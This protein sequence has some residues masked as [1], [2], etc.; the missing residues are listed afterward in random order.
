ME[1][2]HARIDHQF[3]EMLWENGY[4]YKPTLEQTET[5]METDRNNSKKA[6]YGYDSPMIQTDSNYL[7]HTHL[8]QD[9]NHSALFPGNYCN[10]KHFRDSQIV[11]VDHLDKEFRFVEDAVSVPIFKSR[12]TPDLMESAGHLKKIP[13]LASTRGN[14]QA[15]ETSYNQTKPGLVSNN[16]VKSEKL[17][18]EANC[19]EGFHN[20]VNVE[21][22]GIVPIICNKTH[23]VPDEQPR[24]IRC[25]GQNHFTNTKSSSDCSV[26]ASNDVSHGSKRGYDGADEGS[27]NTNEQSLDEETSDSIVPSWGR[28]RAKRF[29]PRVNSL[30]EKRRGRKIN[31]KMRALRKLIPNSNSVDEASMLDEAIDYLKI[32]QLQVQMMSMGTGLCL[33]LMMPQMSRL[34]AL[35]GCNSL[36]NFLNFPILGM[37]NSQLPV[38]PN[39]FSQPPI[40]PNLFGVGG[41][42]YFNSMPPAGL[43]LPGVSGYQLNP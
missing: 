3:L 8:H 7:K 28:T 5:E 6:R 9:L 34:G 41:H 22:F 20:Q 39:A 15:W 14:R 21:E 18:K 24:T 43:L 23:P 36:P 38:L 27:I 10:D 40:T 35:M 29:I 37:T 13:T 26:E 17:A 2:T 1:E 16:L 4:V 32:L 25:R 33:P 31:K 11:P 12:E 30:S 19:F 42:P